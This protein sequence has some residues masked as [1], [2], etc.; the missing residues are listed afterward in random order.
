MTRIVVFALAT[1]L[2]AAALASRA[3]GVQEVGLPFVWS[4]QTGKRDMPWVGKGGRARW[5]IIDRT[6]PWDIMDPRGPKLDWSWGSS[7]SSGENPYKAADRA[8][9]YLGSTGF[10]KPWPMYPSDSS[11]KDAYALPFRVTVVAIQPLVAIMRFD[12][13][14]PIEDPIEFSAGAFPP[15]QLHD[16]PEQHLGWSAAPNQLMFGTHVVDRGSLL[17]FSPDEKVPPTPLDVSSGHA[18]IALKDFRLAVDRKG[19]ELEVT[20]RKR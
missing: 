9:A 12:L 13:A 2:L 4:D 7:G 17:W 1:S 8:M 3:Q 5:F 16:Y 11:H 18:E 14:A 19:G 10:L 15:S 6:R 20:W